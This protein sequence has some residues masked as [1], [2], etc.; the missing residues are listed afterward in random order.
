VGGIMLDIGAN[1]G[2][3]SIPRVAL[4]D[5]QAVY[6][7]E[8]EPR[9]YAALVENVER[10]GLLGFILPD[11]VAIA[12][13]D[14]EASLHLSSFMGR[15][16]LTVGDERKGQSVTVPVRTL[17][18]WVSAL[19]VD[20]SDVT[21]IKTD[22]QGW[23]GHVLRGAT[24]ILGHRHILWQIEYWPEGIERSSMTLPE[25]HAIVAGAFTHGIDS[26]FPN[27]VVPVASLVESLEAFATSPG[28]GSKFTELILF[29]LL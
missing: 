10:N 1:I 2:T 22:C 16:E 9:N 11:R 18:S 6:C 20:A 27:A 24:T 21:F 17:D 7:A 5:F 26:R 3:T 29:N 28:W 23:D 13:A 19:G 25:L 8:P 4:G 14:G 12:D 15:H